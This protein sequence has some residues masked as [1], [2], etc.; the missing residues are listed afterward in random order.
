MNI[1]ENLN[2]FSVR[3]TS[4]LKPKEVGI[5]AEK[6]TMQLVIGLETDGDFG[7][8]K[9]DQGALIGVIGSKKMSPSGIVDPIAYINHPIYVP[10]GEPDFI[11]HTQES[12]PTD[13]SYHG[14]GVNSL[15]FRA[16]G[17]IQ[18]RLSTGHRNMIVDLSAF[19][20]SPYRTLG[21]IGFVQFKS[22][23]VDWKMDTHTEAT[24][25]RRE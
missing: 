17:I 1:I 15:L 4:T 24:I 23:Q 11:P 8:M 7:F 21:D 9:N 6:S 22:W 3:S 10:K 2:K 18:L 14:V 16:D 20:I 12:I 5:L 25:W 13:F 19:T